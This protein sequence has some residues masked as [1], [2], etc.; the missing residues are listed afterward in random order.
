MGRALAAAFLD[1]G[2]PTTVWNRTAARADGLGARLASGVAEAVSA[3]PLVIVCMLDY[4]A[5]RAILE[6][7][8]A[9]LRGR[10]VVNLTADTPERARA[11]AGWAAAHGIDYLDG[12]IMTPVSTIGGPA[13]LTF[14]SGPESVFLAHRA[15]LSGLGGTVA[16]LARYARGIADLLPPIIDEYAGQIA[17]GR[18]PGD[19]ANLRSAAA[20]MAHIVETAQAHGIDS[21]ALQAVHAVA[22]QAIDAGHGTD[23]FARLAQILAKG[24]A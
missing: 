16:D 19:D 21:G 2:H 14:Y 10:A 15:T 8:A 23:S 18:Y 6:P 24:A 3:G 13:A 9:A 4:A 11:M 5:A 12:A 1:R 20:S 7:A 22:R 17:D